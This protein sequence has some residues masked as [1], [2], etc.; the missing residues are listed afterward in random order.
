MSSV[1]F[2]FVGPDKSGSSWLFEYLREHRQCYVPACKDIYFFDRYYRNGV[3]WYESLFKGVTQREIAVGEI[4][5]DYLFSSTAADRIYLYNPNMKI[6]T[7]L[8][9]PVRRSFSHYLY[10]VRSGLTKKE[11]WDA[12]E[13]FPEIIT[14][15]LYFEPV[16]TY[17]DKFSRQNVGILIFD[18]LQQDPAMY[19]KRVCTF[20]GIEFESPKKN[21][22]VRGAAKPRSYLVAKLVKWVAVLVRSL[23]FPTVVG[24]IKHSM[25]VKLLYSEY[26]LDERPQLTDSDFIKLGKYFEDDIQRLQELTG[27]P[28]VSYWLKS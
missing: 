10:L 14:N 13:E 26:R 27:I 28:F 21:R 7:S 25:I 20:L 17:I 8:R 24:K 23:G 18:E 4:C 19:A 12:V 9:H 2:L 22:V 16:K 3:Q 6:L 11:F 5:H 15:S 1:N